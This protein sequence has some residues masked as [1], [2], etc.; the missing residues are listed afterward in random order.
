MPSDAGKKSPAAPRNW[1]VCLMQ[2]SDTS[3]KQGIIEDITFW[4]G[5]D[6]TQ[7]A[8]ADRTR[9]VNRHY[10]DVVRAILECDAAWEFDDTDKTDLPTLTTTLVSGQK[11]YELPKSLTTNPT[12]LQGGATAGAILKIH[13]VEVLDSAGIW[14]KLEQLDQREIGV[15]LDEFQKNSGIPRFYD[16]RGGSIFLYPAPLTGMVT[17]TA[18]LKIYISREPYTFLAADTTREPGFA[19]P[20][21]RI[22]S[23]GAAFDWFMAKNQPDKAKNL[24]VLMDEKYLQLRDFYGARNKDKTMRVIPRGISGRHAR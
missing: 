13:R 19:E 20:F 9:N 6:T 8:T 12:T 1:G 7:Y 16:P 22:L 21:H 3:T 14:S 2:F 15:A 18:G 10:L 5:M 11:D 17:L 4:T 23:Y 24:K